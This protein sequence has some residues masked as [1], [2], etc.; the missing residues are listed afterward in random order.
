MTKTKYESG[1]C[2]AVSECGVRRDPFRSSATW[3]NCKEGL[4]VRNAQKIGGA[5]GGFFFVH[6]KCKRVSSSNSLA[7]QIIFQLKSRL[8]ITNQRIGSIRAHLGPEGR[9]KNQIP[10]T[11]QIVQYMAKPN[12]KCTSWAGP[13]A[14]N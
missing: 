1:A 7:R 13:D 10:D 9:K 5:V 6:Q 12:K 8:C 2:N 4:G 3:P 14:V 11:R